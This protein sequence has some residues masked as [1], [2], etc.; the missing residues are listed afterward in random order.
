MN[1]SK[2][3]GP[4]AAISARIRGAGRRRG[5]SAATPW[6]EYPRLGESPAMEEVIRKA[7]SVIAVREGAAEP[8]VLVLERSAASRF[9]PGYVVFPGGAADAGDA[10]LAHAVVRLRRTRPRAPAP[11]GSSR[12][13][14]ACCSPATGSSAAATSSRGRARSRR[15]RSSASSRA[16]SRPEE[17]PVRFDARYFVVEAGPGLEPTPDGA[18]V[19]AGWWISPRELLR[20][21]EAGDAAP[22]LAHLVHGAGAR[23]RGDRRR[24]A[25]AAARDARARRRRGRAAAAL[26]LLAGLSRVLRIVRV[27]APNADVYTLDGTNTWVVGESPVDRDRP[28]PGDPLAPRRGRRRR[29]AGRRGARDARSSRPRA[30]PPRRSPSASAR[31][32]SR[33]GSTAREHLRDGQVVRAGGGARSPRCTRPGHTSD[34]LAFFEPESRSLFTGDAVVGRGTSFIDPPGG[35]LAQYLRSL[36]RMRGLGRPH[37]LSGPRPGGVRR[38]RRSS[39]STCGT[40]PSARSRCWPRSAAALDDRRHGRADLRR[41]TRPRSGRSPPGRCWPTS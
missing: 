5:R 35:D 12:R 31:R 26:G 37:D 23:P 39:T 11:C 7:A 36:E 33:S 15:R 28:G 14:P 19:V 2:P 32:S 34:H 29:R 27:L 9:L 40:A 41:T 17:V 10:E 25:G 21:W 24:A 22:L 16:G 18:E 3:I 1:R 38:R 30:R 13:R 4:D 20:E 6:R 8:E